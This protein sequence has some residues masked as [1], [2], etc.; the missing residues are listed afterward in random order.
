MDKQAGIPPHTKWG[1]RIT[2]VIILLISFLIIKNCVGSV[3]YGV[4]TDKELQNQYYD[5]GYSH[6]VQKA[7]GLEPSPEPDIKNLL[8]KKEY[9]KGY[10]NGWDSIK[11]ELKAVVEPDKP[12]PADQKNNLV[13]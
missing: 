6:G 1:I 3:F 2:T 13:K 12:R 4:T 7:K 8:L 10:R 5:L 11:T 9:R